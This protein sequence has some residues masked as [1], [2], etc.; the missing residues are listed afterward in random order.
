LNKKKKSKVN[1]KT[2][3]ALYK[4]YNRREFVHP[5]PLEFLYKYDDSSDREIAGLV[6]SS[7]AYGKVKQILKS[8]SF[9]LNKMKPSPA[10]F[11]RLTDEKDLPRTFRNFKHRW[12]T[13]KEIA[14]MLSGVKRVIELYG[15][16]QDCFL[17]GLNGA[18]KTVLPALIYFV[19]DLTGAAGGDCA[20]LLP[21]PERGSACKRLNLFLR[22]M[23][24][25]DDVDP[26]VWT[27]VAP[28]KLIVP[29]DTHMHCICK[30][31]GFTDRNQADMKTALEVTAAFR[32]FVPKD[33][34]KYD[35][36]L[37]RLG[38]RDDTD[39]SEFLSG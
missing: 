29:L 1:K 39:L 33:P 23:V 15:S 14:A 22:W 25:S 27:C 28:S 38:I 19:K 9:V 26:G 18:D 4:K 13:G 21:A 5:D 32:K 3:E 8:V 31:I 7:L 2:L 24:R 30:E 10:E 34:A 16:L 20:S 37:T 11:L 17:E 35:F 36:A 6:A 12:S